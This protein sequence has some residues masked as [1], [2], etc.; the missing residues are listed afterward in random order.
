MLAVG[1]EVDE[2]GHV[3]IRATVVEHCRW[4]WWRSRRGRVVAGALVPAGGTGAS[5]IRKC[6]WKLLWE[7]CSE[8]PNCAEHGAGRGSVC[9]HHSA[10][11]SKK[12]G[13]LLCVLC[14]VSGVIAGTIMSYSVSPLFLERRLGK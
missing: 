11:S 13:W 4:S 6:L 10:G 12:S 8:V 1:C 2:L 3:A 9:S 5:C 7:L 14:A